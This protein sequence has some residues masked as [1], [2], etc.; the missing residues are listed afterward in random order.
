MRV[1]DRQMTFE[2]GCV[3][4]HEMEGKGRDSI[5]RPRLPLA[6]KGYAKGAVTRK[7]IPTDLQGKSLHLKKQNKN[8]SGF[9][10]H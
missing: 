2:T 10:T 9:P 3:K 5:D 7:E 4:N 8:P 1:T 6:E